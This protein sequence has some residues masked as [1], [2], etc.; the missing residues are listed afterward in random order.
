MLLSG[1]P[2][3]T[4]QCAWT[5]LRGIVD[6]KLLDASSDLSWEFL[7]VKE[8]LSDTTSPAHDRL[9]KIL[10]ASNAKARLRFSEFV[11]CKPRPCCCL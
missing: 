2:E 3:M 5:E 9:K 7:R 6:D 11:L 8:E 4:E 1:G 10:K